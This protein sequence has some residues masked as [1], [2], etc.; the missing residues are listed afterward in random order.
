MR[1]RLRTRVLN[2]YRALRALPPL[3]EGNPWANPTHP[4][5][6]WYHLEGEYPLRPGERR[7]TH[8]RTGEEVIYRLTPV[9]H[10]LDATDPRSAHQR[11]GETPLFAPGV[12]TPENSLESLRERLEVQGGT[13]PKPGDHTYLP[14]DLARGVTTHWDHRPVDPETLAIWESQQHR[15]LPPGR[16]G[17][18][19]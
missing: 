1:P 12:L 16:R 9:T 14:R 11:L 8:P 5:D 17:P 13:V 18:G 4:G 2:A 6:R 19:Q 15:R 7:G 10:D 3:V